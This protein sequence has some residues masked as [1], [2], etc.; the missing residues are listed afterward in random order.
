MTMVLDH[1]IKVNKMQQ[2]SIEIQKNKLELAKG[3]NANQQLL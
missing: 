2:Q 1:A 3:A